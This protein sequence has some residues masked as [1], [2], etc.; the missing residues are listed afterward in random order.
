MARLI[1]AI[2]TIIIIIIII[3]IGVNQNT[4]M[5]HRHLVCLSPSISMYVPPR[6]IL[7]L[8]NFSFLKSL[9]FWISFST[10]MYRLWLDNFESPPSPHIG[11]ISINV[12]VLGKLVRSWQISKCLWREE[13]TGLRISQQFRQIL[14][15]FWH[16][17]SNFH[18]SLHSRNCLCVDGPYLQYRYNI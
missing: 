18:K 10:S 8:D 7:W 15:Y 3:I 16:S 4:F 6:R 1:I 17:I 5:I 13:N 14:K 2:I 11:W 12:L 9:E